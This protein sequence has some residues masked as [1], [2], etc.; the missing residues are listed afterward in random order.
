MHG[1][2]GWLPVVIVPVHEPDSDTWFC[3]AYGEWSNPI[4][5]TP[6]KS[7]RD[8]AINACFLWLHMHGWPD[9]LIRVS[10]GWKWTKPKENVNHAPPLSQRSLFRE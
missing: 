1:Y 2:P 10:G 9:R 4:W 6:S 8:S 5:T 7:D 3:T